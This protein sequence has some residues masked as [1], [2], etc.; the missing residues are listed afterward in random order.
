MC[1]PTNLLTLVD[2]VCIIISL[3]LYIS[4]GCFRRGSLSSQ[5]G[6]FH[7]VDIS[8]RLLWT[9]SR[10]GFASVTFPTD[11]RAGHEQTLC[12]HFSCHDLSQLTSRSVKVE[13]FRPHDPTLWPEPDLTLWSEPDLTLKSEPIWEKLDCKH[14]GKSDYF[15]CECDPLRLQKFRGALSW[16]CPWKRF[17]QWRR[18]Y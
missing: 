17:C 16:K 11:I 8:V 12:G 5:Q 14:F 1:Y 13:L 10:S 18:F 4:D 15:W 6:L 2:G 3:S 7:C 9:E